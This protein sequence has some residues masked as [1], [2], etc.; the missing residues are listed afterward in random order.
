MRILIRFLLWMLIAALP[1][2]GN[3]FAGMPCA[4]M[5]APGTMSQAAMEH[6]SAGHVVDRPAMAD[7]R[8]CGDMA[9]V[10]GSAAPA[11]ADQHC[12]GHADGNN[13]ADSHGKCSQ[14]AS[15]CTGAVAPPAMPSPVF[16]A[17]FSTVA[18]SAIEPAMIAHVPATPKRPPRLHV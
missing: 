1:L 8:H 9:D 14:C 2:Q 18:P 13:T 4:D 5:S 10:A 7:S 12:A 6:A 17:S 16:P 15:C 3:A 11:A